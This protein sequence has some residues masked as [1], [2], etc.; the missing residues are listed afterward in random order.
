[1]RLVKLGTGVPG[2]KGKTW[3]RVNTM[4]NMA[5]LWHV[6]ESA[7][8]SFHDICKKV[9][10][11]T[12]PVAQPSDT[13]VPPFTPHRH[14]AE[15]GGP[16]RA[17]GAN[18]DPV[19]P[20]PNKKPKKDK[21]DDD[22]QQT[23]DETKEVTG[24]I[25]KAKAL[26]P[27]VDKVMAAHA[28][29][30]TAIHSDAKWAWANNNEVLLGPIRDAKA[31]LDSNKGRN[32]FWKDWTMVPN[33]EKTCRKNYPVKTLKDELKFTSTLDNNASELEIAMNVVHRMK[34]ALDKP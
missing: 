3:L 5:E 18:G 1:M 28:E 25:N 10:S 15:A 17:K 33:W 24:L 23:A 20:T 30:M 31:K 29:L 22:H 13:R 14:Q 34:A 12:P 6:E 8:N 26:K 16:K 27:R 2:F 19:T 9:Q 32:Q 7:E 4:T 21:K 11:S